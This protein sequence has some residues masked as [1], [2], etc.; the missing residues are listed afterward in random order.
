MICYFRMAGNKS[1]STESASFK[2]QLK[3][4]DICIQK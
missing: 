1:G 4:L 3:E 2:E